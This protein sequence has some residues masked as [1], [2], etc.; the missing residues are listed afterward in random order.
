MGTIPFKKNHFIIALLILVFSNLLFGQNV[1]DNF[2]N[3]PAS[4]RPMPLWFMNGVLSFEE[5]EKQLV[6]AKNSGFGGVTVLP[7]TKSTGLFDTDKT[8][9]GVEPYYLTDGYFK[10]YKFILDTCNELGMKVIWY[11]DVDF[12]SGSAGRK[13]KKVFPDDIRKILSKKDT[14]ISKKIDITVD[15]SKLMAVVAM[16]V[17]TKERIDLIDFIKNGKL[18]WGA[19]EGKWKVMFFQC[20][21]SEIDKI[22]HLAVDYLD[23]QAIDKYFTLNHDQFTKR[24][25]SYFGSTIFQMFFDDVGYFTGDKLGEKT[26]T[27]GFNDKFEAMYGFSPALYYPALWENIGKDTQA[28][29]VALFNTRAELLAE[30]FPR[31]TKEWAEKLN[32]KTSG[33]PPG[34]YELQPTD[35]Q[36][37]IFKY[38]RHSDIPTVDLIFYNAHG[39]EGYKLI[40]STAELYNR[41]QVLAEIYGAFT[42]MKKEE[43]FDKEML[44]RSAMDAF[45]RGVN[46]LVPHAMWYDYDKDHIRIPP[47]IATYNPDISTELPRFNE[48]A[49]RCSYMLQEGQLVSDIAILYPIESLQGW[50]YF[51]AEENKSWGTFAAPETDYL[52]VG[53]ELTNNIRRDF[54][55]VHPEYFATDKYEIDGNEVVLDNNRHRY[56]VIILPGGDVSSVSTLKKVKAF[57]DAGGKVIATSKLPTKSAEFGKDAL[58]KQLVASIFGEKPTSLNTNENRGHAL[59][60]ENPTTENLNNALKLVEDVPD[61]VFGQ[62]LSNELENGVFN[63]IHKEKDGKDIYFFS[64]SSNNPIN[65]YVELKGKTT[66]QVWNPYTG[67]IS[68]IERIDYITNDNDTYTRIALNL[69]KVSST[70]IISK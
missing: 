62:E 7:T 21:T 14:I 18:S 19:P 27:Y 59:F 9:P 68:S 45:S 29:R 16:N 11:D 10:Y 28:A 66:P 61:V 49:A 57:Y 64:N 60:V 17:Q 53:D 20:K 47:L 26:W 13:M 2:K 37:D 6:D 69:K 46:Q 23:P 56:K 31:K 38:Y 32:I 36:S 1:K 50:Y 3:I 39:R 34:N 5:I 44:Y 24:F 41:P 58:I 70:F 4:Y 42:L 15:A 43:L 65:T 63:Y 35:F 12:P 40:S 67:E 8:Y 52:K 54:S 33:H 22:N 55:F 51:D 30:G 48:W 25:S